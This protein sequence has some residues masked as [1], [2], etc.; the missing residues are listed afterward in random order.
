LKDGFFLSSPVYPDPGGNMSILDFIDVSAD[1]SLS[2][3]DFEVLMANYD[4]HFNK[5]RAG[6]YLGTP[7]QGGL[8]GIQTLSAILFQDR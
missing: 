4:D 5:G 6:C 1:F 2:F 7:E 3:E 8:C